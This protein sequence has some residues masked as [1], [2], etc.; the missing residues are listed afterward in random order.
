MLARPDSAPYGRL[1]PYRAPRTGRRLARMALI[2]FGLI[3]IALLVAPWQ[4]N[5]PASG[6]V[7]AYA[8]LERQQSID[9]PVE[10]RVLAWY[11]EEGQRVRAGDL[12]VAL[13]DNDPSMLERLRDEKIAVQ[14]RIDAA[15]TRVVA[16]DARVDALKGSRENA[17]LAADSR[18]GMAKDR[19][20]ASEQALTAATAAQK[21]AELNL[22]RVKTLYEDGLQSKRALEV[23]ELDLVKAK[24]DAER[25]ATTLSAARFEVAALL[26]DRGKVGND[27]AASVSDATATKAAALAE[28]ATGAAE[29]AR[30]EVRLSRQQAQE[31]RAP[32]DGTVFRVVAKQGGQYIKSGDPL[33]ILVPDALDRAVEVWVDGNDINLVRAGRQVRLQF[34][35]WPAVQFSGWPS[36]AVG[37]YGGRVAFVDALDD[38]AG[39]FRVVVVPDPNDEPWPEAEMLRQGT[40]ANGFVLME[41]VSLG[42]ELWRTFNGFPKDWIDEG[43]KK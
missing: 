15:K 13:A 8:A 21:T 10:G 38:G 12:L 42:Y 23:A 4:Q 41:R 24:T 26:A 14:A 43:K 27:A 33:A 20:T 37:T 17:V 22:T 18:L 1:L 9:A 6:R 2:A 5:S 31:V 30:I 32:R 36:A 16:V 28:V 29:L 40:R 34:E 19:V 25:A 7:I 3:A 35:G 39:R 11:V